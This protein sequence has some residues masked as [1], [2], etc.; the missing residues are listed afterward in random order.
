MPVRRMVQRIHDSSEGLSGKQD[1]SQPQNT[2]F[3]I[4][5]SNQI[6]NTAL[7]SAFVRCTED[8][9]RRHTRKYN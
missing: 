2:R 8:K 4:Y 9:K 1:A 7:N 5:F 3:F 6:M